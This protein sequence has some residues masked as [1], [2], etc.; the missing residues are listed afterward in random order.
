VASPLQPKFPREEGEKMNILIGALFVFAATMAALRV[1]TEHMA[2]IKHAKARARLVV[3]R[4]PAYGRHWT[5]HGGFGARL[6]VPARL[7]P[8]AVIA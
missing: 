8:S 1:H 6:S 3:E 5:T 4:P 2:A 7:R